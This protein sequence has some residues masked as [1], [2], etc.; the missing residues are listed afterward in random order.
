[1]FLL[2]MRGPL[3]WA[4]NLFI[5]KKGVQPNV[6]GFLSVL[7]FCSFW[8]VCVLGGGMYKSSQVSFYTEKS[9]LSSSLLL[10]LLVMMFTEDIFLLFLFHKGQEFICCFYSVW[11]LVRL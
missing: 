8:C 1:M 2:M 7:H 5:Q 10:K 3:F 9:E 11:V 4:T 6:L